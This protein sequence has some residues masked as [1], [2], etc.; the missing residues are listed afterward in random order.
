MSA[1]LSYRNLAD[2]APSVT[3]SAV[4][5]FPLSNLLTRQLSSTW[6]ADTSVN[7]EI[8][9]DLGADAGA[10]RVIALLGTNRAGPDT[11]GADMYVFGSADGASW[12]PLAMP[13]G[14][15]DTG[16]PDLPRNVITIVEDAFMAGFP[17]Y[18]RIIPRWIPVDG[19]SY[20]EAGR[21]WIGDALVLPDE[22]DGNWE[23]SVVDSG[24][25]D[26]SASKQVYINRGK[27]QRVLRMAVTL[28]PTEVA[29]GFS[30]GATS[31][32]GVPSMQDLMHHV[33]ATG[34]VLALIRN[35][36]NAANAAIW[37][38][39]AGIYGR[40]SG[41]SLTIRHDDG[42]NYSTNLSIIEES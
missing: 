34:E 11:G 1:L 19:A 25:A 10:A 29:F 20:F 7:P 4:A 12:S 5:N 3:G 13:S 16:V 24:R 6:R 40:L 9:V 15:D 39:R 27:R 18:L 8:L 33:G 17:R 26:E 23:L 37:A 28:M 31:A 30:E 35:G 41:D 36:A 22:C 2:A 14:P 38:R 21:L 32:T 42:P